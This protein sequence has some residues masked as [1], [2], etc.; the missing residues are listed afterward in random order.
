M[1]AFENESGKSISNADSKLKLSFGPSTRTVCVHIHFGSRVDS[2]FQ[3]SQIFDGCTS[4]DFSSIFSTFNPI[5][6]AAVCFW[7]LIEWGKVRGFAEGVFNILPSVPL[8]VGANVPALS[9]PAPCHRCI[10]FRRLTISSTFAACEICFLKYSWTMQKFE[11]CGSPWRSIGCYI[12]V[13]TYQRIHPR[14]F[15]ICVGKLGKFK[16]FIRNYPLKKL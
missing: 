14:I 11:H 2:I 5:I 15:T 7:E 1:A 10:Y 12:I 6:Y 9:H 16:I 4:T 8:V 3:F 13:E